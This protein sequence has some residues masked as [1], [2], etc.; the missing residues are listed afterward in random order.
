M[1]ESFCRWIIG[2]ETAGIVAMALYIAKQWKEQRAQYLAEL[3]SLRRAL[4][5]GQSEEGGD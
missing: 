5:R 1:D 3:K 4:N 2:G